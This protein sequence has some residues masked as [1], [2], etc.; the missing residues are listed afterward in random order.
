MGHNDIKQLKILIVE[1]DLI[2]RKQL[3]RL[4]SKSE[5]STS[6]VNHTEYLQNALDLLD[7]EDFDIVLLDLNL[8]DSNGL[9]TLIKISE[10]HPRVANIV[11]TGLDD[12]S[13][14]LKSVAKGA[15]DYLVKGE[16]NMEM[17]N[18]SIYYAIERKKAELAMREREAQYRLLF[19]SANE[20]IFIVKGEQLLDCNPPTLSIFGCAKE[21]IVGQPLL[22]F[23]PELQPDG[24]DSIEK[25]QE[26][27]NLALEGS[28]QF[29]EW[30]FNRCDKIPFDAEVSL[31]LLDLSGETLLQAMVRDITE[32]K[33]AA[34][35]LRLAY[36]KLEGANREMK[37]MQSQMVQSEKL[38]S[39]GQLAAGVAHEMNTPVGFTASNFETL[40]SYMKKIRDLLKMYDE[41]A[42]QIESSEKEI[43]LNKVGA[44]GEYR[45]DKKIDF[46]LEDIQGL[47]DDSKE[48]LERVTGI[49]QNLRDFSRIDQIESFDEHNINEGIEATLV[50]AMNEIKYYADVKT[51]FAE[52]PA[53]YCNSG[54]INQVFLNILVNAAQA[55]KSKQRNENEKGTITIRT[56]S[57]TEEVICEIEDDGPGI[58]TDK[59]TKV[60]DPFFTT[61]PAGKGTGLGLSVSYDII[62]TKHKGKLFVESTLGKGTKFTIRLPVGSK[63][64]SDKKEEVVAEMTSN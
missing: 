34:E 36:E 60:F 4:L 42:S 40:Q 56:Y 1:D 58:E 8:P 59:L 3:E 22:Q 6:E 53:I 17:L 7:K 31:N 25:V 15:Q 33:R 38:A 18:K 20:A 44:I 27:I 30:R 26:K 32:R 14:G 11:V 51:D 57:N 61:K 46:V 54:Q 41:L 9:D 45:K 62:V 21:Q 19:E 24:Q 5:L 23:S 37:E 29:F 35:A 52:V 28:P 55:I 39:I 12:E 48:G 47:F 43:L 64:A 2:D 49:I 63:K 13:F 16:F 50:V 10:K